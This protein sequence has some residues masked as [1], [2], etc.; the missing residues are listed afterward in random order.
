MK[1]WLLLAV[2]PSKASD[3]TR[4]AGQSCGP[5]HHLHCPNTL[6]FSYSDKNTRLQLQRLRRGWAQPCSCCPCCETGKEQGTE[7]WE[8]SKGC[9][10]LVK[11]QTLV[12][13]HGN[14]VSQQDHLR[15]KTTAEQQTVLHEV[16]HIPLIMLMAAAVFHVKHQNI[17]SQLA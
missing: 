3:S 11:A 6:C 8:S 17:F 10:H 9:G 13:A 12:P 5:R 14:Q 7:G 2:C 1:T 4:E 16:L 15:A